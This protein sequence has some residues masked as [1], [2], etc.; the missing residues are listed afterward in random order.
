MT[1]RRRGRYGVTALAFCAATLLLVGTAA[2][3]SS[4]TSTAGAPASV[5]ELLELFETTYRPGADLLDAAWQVAELGRQQELERY[6]RLSFTER[7]T[8][9]SGQRITLDL[10][11]TATLTLYRSNAELLERLQEQRVRMLDLEGTLARKEARS[12]FQ[13][14]LLEL[15]LYRSLAKEL[16]GA[17][18]VT[19]AQIPRPADMEAALALHPGERDPLLLRRNVESLHEQVVERA[20]E[21]EEDIQRTLRME[22]PL[23]DLPP[24]EDL[25]PLFVEAHP[26]PEICLAES[27]L[28]RQAELHHGVQRSERRAQ[29]ALDFRVELQG[30]SFYRGGELLGSVGLELRLPLPTGSPVAGQVSLAAD[31]GTVEQTLRLSWPPSSPT[32]R[33]VDAHERAESLSTERTS[34]ESE[35][36]NLFRSL[37]AARKAVESAELQLLWLVKDIHG[38]AA[39]GVTEPPTNDLTELRDLSRR[40]VAEPLGELQRVRYLSELLFAK[41]AY[42]EQA[43]TV[44]LVCGGVR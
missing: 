4:A 18:A 32:M 39:W 35:L 30:S 29:E 26:E 3:G 25:L 33:P 16:A 14:Q 17:L 34:L 8:W 23:P 41:L 13:G 1:L 5:H 31:P 10:D 15:S 11:L 38:G 2:A 22:T 40:P 7:A 44:E 20:Q 43:L 28:L 9:R 24:M 37:D 36:L 27:P 6:P 42:A 12:R 21:L 19:A